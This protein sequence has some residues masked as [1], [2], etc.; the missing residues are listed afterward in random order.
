MIGYLNHAF[1]TTEESLP[2]QPMNLREYWDHVGTANMMKII[3][4]VGSSYLHFRGLKYG[5]KRPSATMALAIID[6]AKKHTPGWQPDLELLVRGV[7]APGLKKRGRITPPSEEF[8][9]DQAKRQKKAKTE[10]EAA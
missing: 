9:R 10:Q 7:P 4:E 2:N 6:A 8:L 3:E 5:M 1:A